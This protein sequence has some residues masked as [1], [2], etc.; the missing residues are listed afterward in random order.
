MYIDSIHKTSRYKHQIYTRL[1]NKT[2]QAIHK[3]EHLRN[4]K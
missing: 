4:P 1:A 3:E 2:T